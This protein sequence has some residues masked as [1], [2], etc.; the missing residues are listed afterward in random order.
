MYPNRQQIIELQTDNGDAA[1]NERRNFEFQHFDTFRKFLGDF[2]KI[3]YHEGPR[4]QPPEGVR[5]HKFKC[6]MKAFV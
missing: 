2:L 6:Q 4:V 5:M 1:D 3:E